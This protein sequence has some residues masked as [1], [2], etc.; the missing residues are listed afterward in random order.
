VHA[1][2]ADACDPK[3]DADRR[4]WHRALATPGPDEAVAAELERSA[5]RAQ[6]RGGVAAAAAFLERATELSRDP[7]QRAQRGLAA[8]ELKVMSGAAEAG[9]GLLGLVEAA[10]L[11]ELQ[12]ARA[13]RV[14]ATAAFASSDGRSAPPLLLAAARELEPLDAVAARDTLLDA[15]SAALFV[16]RLSGEVGIA[17]VA[18]VA[19][20]AATASDRPQDLLLE[21]LATV[22]TEGYA[23]GAP[24]LRRAVEA[25]RT[26][27]LPVG[28]QLRWLWLA[29]H[30]AHDVWDD[31]AWHEL[32]DRHVALARSAGALSVLPIA[33]SARIGL[34][35]FAGELATAASLVEEANA[36][37]HAIGTGLPPY[38]ALALAAFRGDEAR[39]TE[40]IRAVRAEVG[41]RGDGMGLTLVEHAEAMLFNGLGRYDAACEAARRGAEHPQELAFSLWSLPQLV[42]AAV[43][44][45]RPE[46]A[47]D[48]L[49]RL[50]QT[51]GPSGTAWA[52]GVEARCR[53]LVADG[54][55][56]ERWYREAIDRLA[57]ARVRAE[58]ARAHLLYG[59]WLRREGRRVDCREQLR[60]AHAML[61]EMGLEAF[62]ERARRELVGTGERARGRNPATRDDLTPQ[63]LQ[64][65]ELARQGLSNPEIGERLFLSPRTVEWH[66]KKVFVK[67]GI[68]SR[69]ALH[70]ALPTPDRSSGPN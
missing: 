36:V 65:A 22:I 44:S 31:E 26:A 34:H 29:T 64:I 54:D 41:P 56:A 30:A 61:S 59:E 70:D 51:T 49:A 62:A 6:R 18:R 68:K 47:A 9:L 45:G 12:R 42:E 16:G 25:F 23:V 21:G 69:M 50:V 27:D 37:T 11:D 67:L 52:L 20:A 3:T 13:H 66:L 28:D 5:E 15:L 8:A 60:T 2:L 43:R 53:A 63:E 32:C 46:L 38:G 55:E 33:L 19:R 57:R 10:A 48:A 35:L 58:H 17:D 7:G 4:A 24:M 14:R 40:L 39:A 1:A